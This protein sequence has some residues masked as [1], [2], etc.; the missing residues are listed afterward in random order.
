MAAPLPKLTIRPDSLE[1]PGDE[2]GD[3]RRRRI[4][5]DQL[6]AAPTFSSRRPFQVIVDEK[7]KCLFRGSR[8]PQWANR[9]GS[10]M[11]PMA[12]MAAVTLCT[13]LLAGSPPQ[14][15][16]AKIDAF[17]QAEIKKQN[18]P[19]VSLA[20]VRTGLP[21]IIRSFGLANRSEEH[22]SELQSPC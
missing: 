11:C 7:I 4:D 9:R 18:V 17:V 16:T 21:P 2:R 20:V 8:L 5:D 15:L 12:R 13:I 1:Q 3:Q 19:G 10:K 14:D 22:T 6:E